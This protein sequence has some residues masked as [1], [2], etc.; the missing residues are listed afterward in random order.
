MQNREVEK[1]VEARPKD[2]VGESKEKHDKESEKEPVGKGN[3]DVNFDVS[4]FKDVPPFPSRFAKSRKEAMDNEFLETFRKVKVNI[5]LLDAIKQVPRYAKF[6]KELCTN[7]RQF[8]PFEKVSMG[9]NISAV[10]QKKLLPKCKDPGMFSI[11]CKIG[12]SIFERCM[13]DLGASINVMPKSVY[14]TFNVGPLSKT[15]VVI[16]LADRS[17]FGVF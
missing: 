12:N 16:Q 3:S 4:C 7:K 10:I 14:D 11:P 5:P 13:L 8:F 2:I 15:Y 17:C 1:E 6:L 9:E